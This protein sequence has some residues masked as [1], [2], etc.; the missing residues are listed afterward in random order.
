MSVFPGSRAS[1]PDDSSSDF[2]DLDDEQKRRLRAIR[3]GYRAEKVEILNNG[4]ELQVSFLDGSKVVVDSKLLKL[5][6]GDL[7]SKAN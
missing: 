5:R 6:A 1:D 7:V 3:R 2:A 4:W